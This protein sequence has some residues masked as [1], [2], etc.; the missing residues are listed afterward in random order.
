[1]AWNNDQEWEKK[2]WGNC[3]NTYGEETKQIVYAKRMGL[4]A[5]WNYGHYPVYD[6]KG[7]SVLD[8]GGGATSLLLKSINHHDSMVVDPCDYPEW[9]KARY[10]EVG[11]NFQNVPAEDIGHRLVVPV[12]D[13]VWCYN[14]LQHT[15]DPELIVNNMRKVSK[16]IRIYE[17][18]NEPVSIGHPHMLKEDLLNKW[19]GGIG[20]VEQM[21]EGGCVGSA[22]FGIFK[23][24]HYV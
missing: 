7:I 12:F 13:E 10:K 20:K 21:N 9:T 17:W 23:G 11:I 14:V 15:I 19:L 1:M 6:L 4:V 8:V 22:Y 2:W 18:V 24:D 5:D 16:I 3:A